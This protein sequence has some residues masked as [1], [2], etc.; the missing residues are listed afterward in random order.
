MEIVMLPAGEPAAADADCIR[1]Q[2]TSSGKFSLAGT[3]LAVCGSAEADE[4]VSLVGSD[5]YESYEAAESAGLAWAN[6]QCAVL[7]YVSRSKGTDTLPD[8]VG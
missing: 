4:V 7:L 2:E 8:V 6:E 3:V 1:I 5:P